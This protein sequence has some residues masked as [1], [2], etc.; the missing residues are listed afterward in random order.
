MR[1]SPPIHRVRLFILAIG[2]LLISST[3]QLHASTVTEA[4]QGVSTLA[5]RAFYG[6]LV[7]GVTALVF[8]ASRRDS[9]Q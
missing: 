3:Q 9:A 7:I 8:F 2:I 6:L 4:S 1:I 5:F